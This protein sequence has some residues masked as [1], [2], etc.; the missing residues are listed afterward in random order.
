MFFLVLTLKALVGVIVVWA[1]CL[2]VPTQ[3]QGFGVDTR[4]GTFGMQVS[5]THSALGGEGVRM[6]V[7]LGELGSFGSSVSSNGRVSVHSPGGDL[8][9]DGN[10]NVDVPGIEWMKSE[11]Q[12]V[13]I[14]VTVYVLLSVIFNSMLI[15]GTDHD[16]SCAV[17]GWLVFYGILFVL[18]SVGC[19]AGLIYGFTLAGSDGGIPALCGAALVLLLV[20]ALVWYWW[21]LVMTFHQELCEGT[22]GYKYQRDLSLQGPP[23][24]SVPSPDGRQKMKEFA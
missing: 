20:N 21:A 24:L 13:L 12:V 1:L 17:L 7:N 9:S 10:R 14:A 4:E 15:H 23:T 19:V 2:S 6:R 16:S 5:E 18:K 8:D 11:Y 3:S 22:R